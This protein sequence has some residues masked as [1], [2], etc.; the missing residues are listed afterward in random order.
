MHSCVAELSLAPHATVK[1][2]RLLKEAP[3][4]NHLSH[5]AVNQGAHSN[6]IAHQFS[7]SG[8]VSR[9]STKVNLAESGAECQLFGLDVGLSGQH[10]DSHTQIKHVSPHCKSSEIYRGVIGKAS[11]GIFYG[12]VYVSGDAKKTDANQ[13]SRGLLLAP[14]A[15]V[16][17]RPE[18]EIYTDDVKCAHGATIGQLD[19]SALFYL[20]SRGV[21]KSV[22]KQM[23]TIGF[24][25]EVLQSLHMPALREAI[26]CEL[27]E[28]L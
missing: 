20:R 11:T 12:Q 25:M 8:K 6:Y 21:S 22:A 2:V 24:A 7:L 16:N 27:G 15:Q 1:H 4:G 9:R 13:N 28:V 17:A 19:E 26:E 3:N 10:C 5:V 23:L 14:D 18:L